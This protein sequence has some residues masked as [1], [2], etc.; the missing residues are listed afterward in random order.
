VSPGELP[1][2]LPAIPRAG[3]TR[4]DARG[5]LWVLPSMAAQGGRAGD[6]AGLLY[7]V[8]DHTGT[9]VERV[10]L[11]AGRALE[12]FGADGAVYLTAHGAG[13]TRLERV[14]LPR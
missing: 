6:G 11:P 9:L 10:R 14:R 8:I 4:V 1:D 13:G 7:D 12:G 3:V 5:R 2:Y